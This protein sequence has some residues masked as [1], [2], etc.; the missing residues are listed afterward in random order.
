MNRMDCHNAW[1]A[2]NSSGNIRGCPDFAR[3]HDASCSSKFHLSR[4]ISRHILDGLVRKAKKGTHVQLMLVFI[5]WFFLRCHC[6]VDVGSWFWANASTNI[7][8]DYP[9]IC[10]F[11]LSGRINSKSGSTDFFFSPVPTPGEVLTSHSTPN[12]CRWIPLGEVSF[13]LFQLTVNKLF[14]LMYHMCI[15]P[16]LF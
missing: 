2:M 10:Y 11:H 9:E 1:I 3:Q 14:I 16:A 6:E 13:R 5:P 4:L 7:F 12:S 15:L 8:A